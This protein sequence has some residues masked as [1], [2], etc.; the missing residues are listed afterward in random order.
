[1]LQ[2]P[3]FSPSTVRNVLK[4]LGRIFANARKEGYLR[5]S[6]M[7]DVEATKV[8][9]TTKGRA[10]KPE[11]VQKVLAPCDDTLRMIVLTALLGGL[12]RAEVFALHWKDDSKEPRSYVDLKEN[13]IRVRKALFWLH[14][15]HQNRKEGEPH[16]TYTT[17]KS[18]ASVRDVPLSPMLKR[19]LQEYYLRSTDKNGLIF[20]SGN[21]TPLDP[22]NVCRWKPAKKESRKKAIVRTGPVSTFTAAVEKAAIGPVRFH[23]LRHTFGSVK[24]DQG[25]NI[26]DIQRWMGHSSIQVTIDI[27]GH[28]VTDRGQEE[29]VKSDAFLF[30]KKNIAAG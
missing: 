26:Y 22:N 15:K 23:D 3:D 9:K 1:L 29:A 10:L 7:L 25:T 14:G 17:P 18:K 24:L 21:G 6:P 5:V 2:T 27:Y 30:G 11:E 8:E 4:L 19:E 12:R 13:V 28:P 16:F 20:Q